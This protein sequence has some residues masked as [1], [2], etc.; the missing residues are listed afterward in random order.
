MKLCRLSIAFSSVALLAFT[1]L[2]SAEDDDDMPLIIGLGAFSESSVYTDMSS[3]TQP[4]IFALGQ[5]GKLRFTGTQVGYIVYQNGGFSVSPVINLI[6][7]DGYD[8]DDAD[9]DSRLYDGL[10]EREGGVQYGVELA[11][12]V[13]LGEFSLAYLADS[14]DG[15]NVDLEFG[16]N[17]HPTD[18]LTVAPFVSVSYRDR[19]FNQYYYGV[20]THRAA[21]N[22][23]AYEAKS[24]V[25]Y[26][27]GVTISYSLSPKWLVFSRAEYNRYD[28]TVTDSPLV[29]DNSSAFIAVGVGYA[30]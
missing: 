16:K 11:Y 29:D 27:G 25:D 26:G 14:G 13:E 10:S 24:G 19:T 7:A 15:Y 12:E 17:F 28:S 3:E 20:D 30:F 5:I 2:V 1:P 4:I 6:G 18:K 23:P 22:R 8:P 21:T 9:N